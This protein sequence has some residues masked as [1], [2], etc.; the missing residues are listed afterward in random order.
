MY[1]PAY[2]RGEAYLAERQGLAA[3]AEFQKSVDH[4]GAVVSD[5]IGALAH[6][7]LGRAFA[8]S[9]EKVKA[10]TAYGDF[11]KQWKDADP[12]ISVLERARI[13]YMN[14]N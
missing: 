10:K 4:P 9:G 5:P 13:E 11:L 14:L 12:R 2:L 6:V 3:A 1:Y 7:Q 8:L